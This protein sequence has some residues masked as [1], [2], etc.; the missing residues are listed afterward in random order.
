MPSAQTPYYVPQW[1]LLACPAGLQVVGNVQPHSVGNT[2]FLV[3][4]ELVVAAHCVGGV[5]SVMP[6]CSN[7]PLCDKALLFTSR[8]VVKY[9]VKGILPTV[10]HQHTSSRTHHRARFL[11]V[12]NSSTRYTT[13][14]C[15]RH[16][17]FIR[18]RL[19]RLV[20]AH[21]QPRRPGL[22]QL[23]PAGRR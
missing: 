4:L 2:Q 1:V 10:H 11:C 15:N 17:I 23:K 5:T 7:T 19:M 13:L 22:Q 18:P 8:M 9:P 21:N 6:C 20:Y 3:T 14:V 16:F 12:V